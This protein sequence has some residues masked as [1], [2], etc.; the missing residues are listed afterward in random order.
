MRIV[1][2]IIG[3]L[4]IAYGI[5]SGNYWFYLGVIPL[6]SGVFNICCMK[7]LLGRCSEDSGCNTDKQSCC[8]ETS[9][10]CCSSDTNKTQEKQS[11]S[12]MASKKMDVRE[13]L[14]L[15]TGCP[16]CIALQKVVEEVV[17]SLESEFKV[18]KID[19]VE[20]IMS[21]GVMSTPGLVIDGNV[22]S[23]GKVLNSNELRRLLKSH[24][25]IED[26]SATVCC[27]SQKSTL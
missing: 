4:L 10:A 16:K 13:I 6:V 20:K 15:G 1:K 3:L 26:K 14:I 2:I 8:S 7:K 25:V 24:E 19:D 22:Q 21:Y 18:G 17:A 5:Y 27:S 12:E 23:V 11:T 9:T